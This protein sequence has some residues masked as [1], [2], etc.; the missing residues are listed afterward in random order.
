VDRA[1]RLELR[2][3]PRARRRAARRADRAPGQRAAAGAR[4]DGPLNARHRVTGSTRI[5]AAR[6]ATTWRKRAHA[7]F[8]ERLG[9]KA[10]ALLL[11]IVLWAV[12]SLKD[13]TEDVFT[14]RLVPILGRGMVL[15]SQPPRVRVLVRG[16]GR[17]LLELHQSPPLIRW[18][19]PV[20]AEREVT[21]ELLPSH[22]VL[23]PGVE[24][25]VEEVMPRFLTVR[26]RHDGVS[27]R[28]EPAA[29][30]PVPSE[31]STPAPDPRLSATPAATPADSAKP[32]S[33]LRALPSPALVPAPHDSQQP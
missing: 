23:P 30:A 13:R 3:Q 32:D 11:A 12:V 24:A 26:V 9:L 7:A 33:V 21:L 17:E 25:D 27:L 29:A 14:A 4:G 6:P 31:A 22:V 8:T 19:L 18:R 5:T 20:T 16:L 10:I 28:Q 1:G 15:E 2:G